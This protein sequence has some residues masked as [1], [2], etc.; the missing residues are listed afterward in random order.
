MAHQRGMGTTRDGYGEVT[1]GHSLPLPVRDRQTGKVRLQECKVAGHVTSFTTSRQSGLASQW[2]ANLFHL[3]TVVWR[4]QKDRAAYQ[5][6][7][8][9]EQP[10]RMF[11]IRHEYRFSH[12]RSKMRHAP[13]KV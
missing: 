11:C 6:D 4:P 3:Q 1:H 8:H 2:L 7:A 9:A 13:Q 5:D 12:S 10:V